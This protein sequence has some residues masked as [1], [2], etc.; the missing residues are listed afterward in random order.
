MYGYREIKGKGERHTERTRGPEKRV[1]RGQI[2]S[3]GSK[4]RGGQRERERSS[5]F[6]AAKHLML[7]A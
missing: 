4:E 3:R 2:E 6:L 7:R 1:E 5:S